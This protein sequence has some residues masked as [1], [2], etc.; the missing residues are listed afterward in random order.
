MISEAAE[1]G[2]RSGQIAMAFPTRRRL[3]GVPFWS[4]VIPHD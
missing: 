4:L 3:D 1:R 2:P